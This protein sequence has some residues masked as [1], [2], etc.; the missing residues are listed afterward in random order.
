VKRLEDGGI[1]VSLAK[2]RTRIFFW[3]PRYPFR[4]ELRELLE[5]VFKFMPEIEIKKYYRKR[6]RPRRTGKPL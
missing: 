5:K 2:G 4:A 3:N 6:Q 1:I